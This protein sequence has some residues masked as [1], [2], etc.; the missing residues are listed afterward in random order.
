MALDKTIIP[1]KI[2]NFRVYADDDILIGAGN[3][4]TLPT[5]TALSSELTAAGVGGT[6]NVP[7]PGLFES[8]EQSTPFTSLYSSVG[9]FMKV[10]GSTNLTIRGAIQVLESGESK[11]SYKGV[12]VNE[13]GWMKEVELGKMKLNEGMDVNGKMEVTYLKVTVD[14][15]EL[16]FIDKLNMQ[17]RVNGKDQMIDINRML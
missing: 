14:G 17:Y 5:V 2:Y 7:T 4:W 8:M 16:L 3:E 12:V 11:M 9:K 1:S 6:V 15:Q 10:G 13:R